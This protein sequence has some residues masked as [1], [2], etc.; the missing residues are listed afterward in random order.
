MVPDG[1]YFTSHWFYLWLLMMNAMSRLT[2]LFVL[3]LGTTVKAQQLEDT[4]QAAA[5]NDAAYLA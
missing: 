5:H 2:V 3:S 1:T 4:Y